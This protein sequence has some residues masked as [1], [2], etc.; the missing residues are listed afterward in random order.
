[1]VVYQ[2]TTENG[3]QVI[4]AET[5]VTMLTAHLLSEIKDTY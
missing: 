3:C 2:Q 5:F 4:M 1:M